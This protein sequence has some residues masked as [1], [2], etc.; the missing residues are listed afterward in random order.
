MKNRIIAGI[1][2]LIFIFGV[3]YL[4][5]INLPGRPIKPEIFGGA[6]YDSARDLVFSGDGY[7]IAGL[8][9]SSGIG[10]VDAFLLKLD[11]RGKQVWKNTFGGEQDD[12]IFS[13]IQ[14]IG[15]DYAA[16][17]YTSSFGA[18]GNDFYFIRTDSNGNLKFAKTYGGKG[19]D[20]AYSLI[21]TSDGGFLLAGISESYN[22]SGISEMYLVRT[23]PEGN[24]IWARSYGGKKSDQASCII[25]SADNGYIVAGT[26]ASFAAGLHNMIMLKVD[27]RGNTLW[28]KTYGGAGDAFGSAVTKLSSGNY[29]VIGSIAKSGNSKSDIFL[30]ETDAQG[31][32]LWSKTYGGAGMDQGV[33]VRE[34]PDKTLVI[35]ATSESYSYG[36]TDILLIKTDPSGNTIWIKHYGTSG[37]DYMGDIKVGQDGSIAVAGWVNTGSNGAYGA[38]FFKTGPSGNY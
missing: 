38:Y 36:S 24:S 18:G 15:G 21:Q 34:C 26:T 10:Y 7:I 25:D 16:A 4:V 9:T 37:D 28:M 23:D 29:A 2:A 19:R 1:I 13:V 14:T 30:V 32:S 27:S 22:K 12:R 3:I 5:F 17:G 20:E 8:T 35:G 6:K 33:A 31:N 11:G